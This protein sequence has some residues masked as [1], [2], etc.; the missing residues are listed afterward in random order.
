MTPVHFPEANIKY[1]PPDDMTEAQCGTIH[2][3]VGALMSGT[4]MGCQ[5]T[6]VAWKPNEAELDDLLAG[7]SVYLTVFGGLPPHCITTSCNS[8]MSL[9]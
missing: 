1:G 3:Y 5:V 9:Q 2:A 8:A 7:K 4:L 6:I